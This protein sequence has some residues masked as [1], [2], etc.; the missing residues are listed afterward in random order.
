MLSCGKDK[1]VAHEARPS[2]SLMFLLHFDALCDH[3]WTNARQHENFFFYVIKIKICEK[4]A[5]LF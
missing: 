3:Y 4:S 5:F 1:K 2:V